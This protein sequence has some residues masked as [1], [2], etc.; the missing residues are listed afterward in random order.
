[1]RGRA[2]I[3]KGENMGY[4]SAS[5][6]AITVT[7]GT[8]EKPAKSRHGIIAGIVVTVIPLIGLIFIL[9]RDSGKSTDGEECTEPCVKLQAPQPDKII[10]SNTY[11]AGSPA[12]PNPD[13]ET[14]Q[15]PKAEDKPPLTPEEIEAIERAK[16]PLYDRHHIVAKKPLLADPVEQLMLSVFSTELGDMPPMLPAI[17]QIDEE[18]MKKMVGFLSEESKDDSEEVRAAK[19]MIN[20]VK[21]ELKKYLDEGGTVDNFLSYYVNELD[22]AFR[23]RNLCKELQ[24]KKLKTEDPAV[25]REYYYLI[26]QRL[27]DKGIKPITLTKRQKEY[28]GIIE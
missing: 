25:A 1:M 9:L 23:E 2:F 10:H 26:N 28:L 8:S 4:S 21:A 7:V 6:K 20:E 18:R 17:P 11:A 12:K 13:L 19:Q 22:A 15:A 24:M 3:C 14:K 5:R 16:D 27:A